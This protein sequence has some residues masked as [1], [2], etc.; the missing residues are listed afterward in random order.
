MESLFEKEI[1]IIDNKC[2][3]NEYKLEAM[4]RDAYLKEDLRVFFKIVKWPNPSCRLMSTFMYLAV[5]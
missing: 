2:F 3:W 5:V 1:K 4:K